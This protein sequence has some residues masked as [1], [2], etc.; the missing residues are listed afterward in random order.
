MNCCRNNPPSELRQAQKIAASLLQINAIKLSPANL[1][2]WASGWRSPIYCD[3][4]RVLSHPDARAQVRDAFAGLVRDKYPSAEVIA[5]VATGAIAHGVL[6]AEALGLPFIYV[7]SAPKGHGLENLIEGEYAHGQRAVVIEDLISTGGSSL[8]AVSALRQAGL[9]VLGMAA[10]FTY[11]FPDAERNFA[12]A[13]VALDTLSDYPTL[14]ALAEQQGYI[15]P[16]D[17]D[18]LKRWRTNPGGF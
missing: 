3:N 11:A 7:R 12:D 16:D 13:G 8:A 18:T 14:I 1:F 2:T 4:R 15:A 6:V 10:I 5:G 17:V 9:D